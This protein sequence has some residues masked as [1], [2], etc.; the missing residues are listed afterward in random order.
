[1]SRGYDAMNIE[2][3]GGPADGYRAAITDQ[4]MD[5]LAGPASVPDEIRAGDGQ[6][7]GHYVKTR[8]LTRSGRLIFE[9]RRWVTR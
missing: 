5:M 8:K 1:M 9:F 6:V 4:V 7:I 3:V 2:F